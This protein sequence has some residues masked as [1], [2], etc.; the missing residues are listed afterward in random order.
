LGLGVEGLNALSSEEAKKRLLSYCGSTNWAHRMTEERP[1]A[2][3]EELLTTAENIWWSLHD[4]DWLEA[5]RSH[6]KIGEQKAAASVSTDAQTW[7]KQEQSS[8]SQAGSDTRRE[9][10]HLNQQYEQRFGYIYIVCATGKS[11]EEML[12]ILRRRMDNAPAEELRV[13]AAEQAKITKLR[14]KKLLEQ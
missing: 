4:A 8:M 12:S 11:P 14:L 7:S 1:F 5:F 6:P 13:A 3:V 2:S 10:A 9:L